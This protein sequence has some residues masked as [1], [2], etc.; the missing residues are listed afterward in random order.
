ML[1][2][3]VAFEK[4]HTVPTKCRNTN[5]PR[6]RKNQRHLL[7]KEEAVAVLLN[8]CAD[9]WLANFEADTHDIIEGLNH[10]MSFKI[11]ISTD[12]KKIDK[13]I[14][15]LKVGQKKILSIFCLGRCEEVEVSWCFNMAG[16]IAK[17]VWTFLHILA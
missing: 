15:F 3:T 7:L 2:Y 8:P 12:K 6:Q 5:L 9:V 17:V 1:S 10:G 4:K 11:A 14:D 16:L 13:S